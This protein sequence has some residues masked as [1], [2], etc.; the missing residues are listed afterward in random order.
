MTFG[1]H[2]RYESASRMSSEWDTVTT[3]TGPRGLESQAIGAGKHRW[4]VLTSIPPTGLDG[5]RIADLQVFIDEAARLGIVEI[6]APQPPFLTD[7]PDSAAVRTG[8][9]AGAVRVALD[10]ALP[11]GAALRFSGHSKVYRVQAAGDSPRLLPALEAAV[12]ASEGVTVA[13]CKVRCRLAP[14]SAAEVTYD[15]FGARGSFTWLEEA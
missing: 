2:R 11:K 4:R 1:D 14:E 12:S 3:A 15:E 9:P 5:G 13:G 8:A 7:L 10:R 6:A